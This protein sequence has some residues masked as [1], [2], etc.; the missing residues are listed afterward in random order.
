MPIDQKCGRIRRLIRSVPA[1]SV[2]VGELV[3]WIDHKDYVRRQRVFP[4]E[5]LFCALVEFDWRSRIG[6]EN[7]NSRRSK[8]I[9]ILDE[10]VYLTNAMGALITG[11]AAENNED[12]GS[13]PGQG[14]KLHDLSCR[15][16]QGKGRSLLADAGHSLQC[17]CAPR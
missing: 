15:C 16:R 14:A 6:D 13:L 1:Q 9:G 7:L 5:E 3:V 17:L 10:I 12:Q 2:L 11:I 4:G 8:L